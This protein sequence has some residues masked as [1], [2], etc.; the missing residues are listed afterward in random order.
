ML[1]VLQ[2]EFLT[3]GFPIITAELVT[4]AVLKQSNSVSNNIIK[5]VIRE[6]LSL[7]KKYPDRRIVRQRPQTSVHVL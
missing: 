2:R 5:D 4:A 6:C 7:L 1:Q 3:T